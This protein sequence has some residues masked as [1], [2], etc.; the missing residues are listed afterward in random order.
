MTKGGGNFAEHERHSHT[1][2]N[3]IKQDNRRSDDNGRRSEQHGPEADNT[4][5]DNGFFEWYAFGKFQIDK[6]NE[7]NRI[8]HDDTRAGN[9]A[10][11]GCGRKEGAHDGV[12]R[13]DAD[14]RKRNRGHDDKGYGKRFEP[15]H[16]HDVNEDQDNGKGHSQ[17]TEDFIRDVPFTVPFHG[18][19]FFEPG[20]DCGILFEFVAFG[21]FKLFYGVAHFQDGVDG[22]FFCARHV[23]DDVYD[24][25]QILPVN[26]FVLYAFPHPNE[27]ERGMEAPDADVREISPR[28][29]TPDLS[30]RDALR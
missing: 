13:Q 18:I 10:N 3:G 14:E 24:P 7:D 27:L 12:P 22:A 17:I 4:C 26:S 6:V 15:P 29:D 23:A 28:R 21:Q 1:L 5:L 20:L 9:K 8:S 25:L 16:D 2:E 11:H 19:C 30:A